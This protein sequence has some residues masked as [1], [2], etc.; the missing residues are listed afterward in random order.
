MDISISCKHLEHSEALDLRIQA[1]SQRLGK[2]LRNTD[3]VNWVCWTSEGLHWAEIR[4][5]GGQ[6]EFFA[7]ASSDSMYKTLDKVVHKLE[8]QLGR[9]KEN[10]IHRE[11]MKEI[12][13][14]NAS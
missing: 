11:G 3:S 2:F 14:M 12:N 10:K 5:Y 13:L 7:K 4:V 9:K 8:M 6:K 1:K